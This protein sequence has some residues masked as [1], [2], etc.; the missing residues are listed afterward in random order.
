[1]SAK[2]LNYNAAAASPQ[3]IP[4]SNA[5]LHSD[6]NASIH[7]V[8]S[9]ANAP[10]RLKLLSPDTPSSYV[11]DAGLPW[12]Q[13]AAL[14]EIMARGGMLLE[15]VRRQ[16]EKKPPAPPS[17]CW[18][19]TSKK[20]L[21]WGGLMLS[22]A[23]IVGAWRAFQWLRSSAGYDDDGARPEALRYAGD[24]AHPA[25]GVDDTH[26]PTVPAN[27]Y[28]AQAPATDEGAHATHAPAADEAFLSLIVTAGLED[29][30]A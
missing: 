7:R 15:Q 26:L 25:A 30:A 14:A 5:A 27:P 2:R 21:F 13:D 4:C 23:G 24:L 3:Q 17:C 22:G 1:M 29:D 18:R 6:A 28:S 12:E 11:S 20:G 16:Q 19:L 8:T 9:I 10:D